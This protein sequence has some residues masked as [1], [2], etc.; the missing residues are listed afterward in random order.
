M[1]PE[2][3]NGDAMSG[4]T[5]HFWR[6]APGEVWAWSL[7]EPLSLGWKVAVKGNKARS[8]RTPQYPKSAHTV[9]CAVAAPKH[10][11]PDVDILFWTHSSEFYNTTQTD[12]L[13]YIS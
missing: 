4:R 6:W 13:T 10:Q 9:L 5:K 3:S 2:V 11:N 1:S 12:L 8:E 7:S